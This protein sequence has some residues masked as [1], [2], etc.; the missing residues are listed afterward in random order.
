[1]GIE[2]DAVREVY[3]D[4]RLREPADD[5]RQFSRIVKVVF[6]HTAPKAKFLKQYRRSREKDDNSYARPDLTYRQRQAEK[7]L[8]TRLK[9]EREQRPDADL[10]IRRGQIV[11]RGQLHNR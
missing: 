3:R 2:T 4:G 8:V 9:A 5:G 6:D 7:L 11:S 1:M 10:I